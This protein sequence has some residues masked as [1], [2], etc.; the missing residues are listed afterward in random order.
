MWKGEFKLLKDML[1]NCHL[2]LDEC[3]PEP[4]WLIQM[5]NMRRQIEPLCPLGL[6]KEQ[7]NL[8]RMVMDVQRQKNPSPTT[9]MTSSGSPPPP[10]HSPLCA[11]IR[12]MSLCGFCTNSRI[13]RLPA[14]QGLGL[15][16]A[17]TW[18]PRFPNKRR[19]VL[20]YRPVWKR[21]AQG[22]L[23]G[24]L[25]TCGS[26]SVGMFKIPPGDWWTAP[27]RSSVSDS[28]GRWRQLIW[29]SCVDGDLMCQA[30]GFTCLNRDGTCCRWER[31]RAT[32]VCVKLTK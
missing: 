20:L 21:A 9:T 15:Q 24:S 17:H 3:A 14:R 7:L 29:S 6:W 19:A 28:V 2:C 11:E 27:G 23:W 10:P 18:N 30:S 4:V 8:I 25:G 1:F 16:P 22:S 13:N 31:R 26:R 32:T 5:E 12:A